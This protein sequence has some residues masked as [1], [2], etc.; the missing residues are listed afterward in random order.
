MATVWITSVTSARVLQIRPLWRHYYQNTQG[1]IFV[2]DSHDQQRF[3]GE[4][5]V[6]DGSNW[7][8]GEV[9]PSTPTASHA[10]LLGSVDWSLYTLAKQEELRGAPIL[11]MVRLHQFPCFRLSS[12]EVFA[13]PTSK[14]FEAR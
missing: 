2:I 10:H 11:F 8:V 12:P 3:K 4:G 5:E 14:T 13:R 9:L 7:Q 1:I 6:Q